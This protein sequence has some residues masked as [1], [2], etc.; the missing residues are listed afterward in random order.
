MKHVGTR[1]I[2]SGALL[3]FAACGAPTAVPPV[4]APAAAAPGPALPIAAEEIGRHIQYLASDEL[5]GRDT[6][7]PGL[8]A[9]AAY[10]VAESQRLG[11]LPAGE[12]GTYLQRWP[13]P[14]RQ[15]SVT[16]TRLRV[17]D[18]ATPV[19]L[20]WGH[21]F[22]A[23]GG[24]PEDVSGALV[25]IGRELPPAPAT[26][27]AGILRDRVALAVLPG[28]GSTDREWRLL[29]TRQLN[30]A[31]RAEALALIHILD[32]RITAEQLRQLSENLARPARAMGEARD[33]P[34]FFLS[35]EAAGRIFAGVDLS[36][37]DAWRQALAGVAPPTTLPG[38]T[39]TGG[40]PVEV[41]EPAMPPNV[42]AVLPGSD[43]DLRNEYVILSAHFDH[44]GV[45]HPVDG[46]SIYNG[47]DDNASGTAGILEVAR[48]L[49]ELP[50]A[51]RRSVLF[52]WVSGE[53]K[54]LLGSRWYSD[55]P[56]VPLEQIVA[57][58]NVDM[59]GGDAHRDTVVIIGKDYSTLGGVVDRVQ[60]G[61]TNLGLVAS[62]DIWPRE[63]FF[64]RSDH[65]N[66]A[67]KEIPALFFFTGVHECYHRPCDDIDFVD[68]GKAARVANLI[69]HT[70]IDIADADARPQWDPAG[71]EQVRALTR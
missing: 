11:L 7:S 52:L 10:L 40:A 28:P 60:D 54:G 22:Y 35:Y 47:A 32:P 69:F 37:D 1:L 39:A 8:E 48:A 19:E 4:S 31:R 49:A 34:E 15:L 18:A 33:I 6:P 12:G 2:L 43:P 51:P 5:R 71:L 68:T 23:A 30:Q 21:D 67:R 59:I 45:G 70:V 20:R 42:V 29:R 56:T 61:L 44:V 62:D 24:T 38:L 13:Y 26:A 63:R 66:F 36:L 65:F 9:A 53:E 27:D 14:L 64:F 17:G 41:L 55:N 58:I 3:A 25:F 16:R 50:T 57:N 46:D